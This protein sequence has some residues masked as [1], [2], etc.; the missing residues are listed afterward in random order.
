MVHISP[1][2]S[3]INQNNKCNALLASPEQNNVNLGTSFWY[4][5]NPRDQILDTTG[6]AGYDDENIQ[7]SI[8]KNFLEHRSHFSM[9]LLSISQDILFALVF[10]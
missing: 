5:R 6:S 3:M 10:L 9:D 7:N 4:P 1:F 8:R 2:M